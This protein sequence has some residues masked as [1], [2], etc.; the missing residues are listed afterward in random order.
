MLTDYRMVVTVN[1]LLV[2][3]QRRKSKGTVCHDSC[4][5][6]I[7]LVIFHSKTEAVTNRYWRKNSKY[8]RA[9]L[10]TPTK[11]RSTNGSIVIL[12]PG[13]SPVTVHNKRAITFNH[14]A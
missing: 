11:L 6:L 4:V 12:I 10:T 14:R 7:H 8:H 3:I 2:R 5:E 1:V 9:G 13:F